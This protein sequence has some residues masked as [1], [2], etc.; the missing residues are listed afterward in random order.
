MDWH[1]CHSSRTQGKPAH[2]LPTARTTLCEL[3]QSPASS[4]S[5]ALTMAI[6]AIIRAIMRLFQFL[7]LAWCTP[8]GICNSAMTSAVVKSTWSLVVHFSWSACAPKALKPKVTM[9]TRRARSWQ[10]FF[11]IESYED[12]WIKNLSLYFFRWCS[13]L[14]RFQLVRWACTGPALGFL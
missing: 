14:T 10:A 5:Q 1:A 13:S 2:G 3:P 8:S 9:R 12:G 7:V 6:L 11:I 4:P